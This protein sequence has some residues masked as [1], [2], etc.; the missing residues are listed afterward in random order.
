MQLELGLK[1]NLANSLFLLPLLLEN[2]HNSEKAALRM[3]ET[4]HFLNHHSNVLRETQTQT[5]SHTSPTFLE[6]SPIWLF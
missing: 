3:R 2:G 6:T 5:S 4:D 1:L